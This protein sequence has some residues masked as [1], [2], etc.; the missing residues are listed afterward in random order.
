VILT[1]KLDPGFCSILPSE[2]K[3]SLRCFYYRP[4]DPCDLSTIIYLLT[5]SSFRTE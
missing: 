3:T 1:C 2:T 4:V 5:V